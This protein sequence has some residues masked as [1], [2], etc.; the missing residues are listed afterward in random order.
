MPMRSEPERRSANSI[1]RFES[2]ISDEYWDEF[3]RLQAARR[4]RHRPEIKRDRLELASFGRIPDERG[5]DDLVVGVLPR[6]A[7]ARMQ[8]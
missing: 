7:E 3:E 1:G 2:R 4:V 8:V 6:I 5:A